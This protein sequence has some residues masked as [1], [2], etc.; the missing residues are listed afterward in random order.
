MVA[1]FRKISKL[2][3]AT[4]GV[5]GGCI[6]SIIS[7][8]IVPSWLSSFLVANVATCGVFDVWFSKSFMTT[9]SAE[10]AVAV[11]KRLPHFISIFA[12]RCVIRGNL[13]GTS[14]FIQQ[15]ALEQLFLSTPL[16]NLSGGPST[17][18]CAIKVMSAAFSIGWLHNVR[19]RMA[20]PTTVMVARLFIHCF[21]W[22]Q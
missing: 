15:I 16:Q 5:T 9:Y 19:R 1:T 14:C 13:N 17:R 18:P 11:V 10:G 8:V 4:I 3:T 6:S 20:G 21:G 7:L 12:G 22:S 2:H